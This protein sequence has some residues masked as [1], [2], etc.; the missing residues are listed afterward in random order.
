MSR[1]G[2]G[3]GRA[4]ASQDPLAGSAAAEVSLPVAIAF[5]LVACLL[6]GTGAGL[7]ADIGILLQPLA[8]QCGVSYQAAS[9]C[10]A[11]MQIVFGAAQ[12]LFGLLAMRRSNRFVLVLGAGVMAASLVGMALSR[13]FAALLVSLGVLFGVG[14]GAVAF[15]LVLTSAIHFVG[16]RRA[17]TV[18]GMLNAAA[19]LVGFALS[20]ALQ[21]TLQAVGTAGTLLA[22]LLPVGALVPIALFVTSRDPA[23][24]HDGAQAMD[25]ARGASGEGRAAEPGEAPARHEARDA[26]EGSGDPGLGRLLRVALGNRTFALLVAG[27]TTCGFHMVIIESHLFNQF[28]LDGIDKAAASWAFSVYGIATILGALLSGWLSSR[29]PKGRLLT[30]YYGFRAVWVALFVF[31]MPKTLACAVAFSVGLGLTGDATVSPT[32]G[33]VNEQFRIEYVATLV[34]TLFLC[35]QVGAFMSAWLGGILLDATGGYEVVWSIDVAACAFACVMSA[36]IPAGRRALG[37]P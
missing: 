30:F 19:G 28:V 6:Y 18:S 33:L 27:F 16:P 9:L 37:R 21:A 29:V 20:P 12:P 32:S 31:A 7:R 2:G 14:A 10:V 11:V 34:G 35:H 15:G 3:A 5:G 8:G 25:D 26:G 4:R 36:R 13:S 17:M 23:E 1:V 24:R 22:L